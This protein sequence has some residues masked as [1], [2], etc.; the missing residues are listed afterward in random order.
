MRY[1]RVICMNGTFDCYR[2]EWD[3][4]APSV[5]RR[6]CLAK[7]CFAPVVG[8]WDCLA[9]EP[10]GAGTVGRRDRWAPGLFGAEEIILDH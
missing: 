9:M 4:S 2:G 1:V 7:D 6:D 10:L 8:R 3:C 5:R